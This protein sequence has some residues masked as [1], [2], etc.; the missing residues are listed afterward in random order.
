MPHEEAGR[1]SAKTST[2]TKRARRR[3][4]SASIQ[5][6][7]CTFETLD[8][9]ARLEGLSMSATVLGPLIEKL[10]KRDPEFML[11]PF[12]L[13]WPPYGEGDHWVLEHPATPS[14]PLQTYQL[15]R[16]A[17]QLT[18]PTD[19]S[20]G[21][22]AITAEDKRSAL[23]VQRRGSSIRIIIGGYQLSLSRAEASALADCLRH[24]AFR[25]EEAQR[26]KATAAH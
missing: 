17:D 5:L 24:A 22:L 12:R 18:A 15:V 14:F 9:V 6:P 20:I 26:A 3:A 7:S 1:D 2:I 13:K 8:T 10:K 19:V 25:H 16:I 4:Y 11:P 23:H 21:D